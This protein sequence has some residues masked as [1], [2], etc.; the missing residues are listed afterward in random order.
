MCKRKVGTKEAK[1]KCERCNYQANWFS[2]F[3]AHLNRKTK[4]YLKTSEVKLCRKCDEIKPRSEFGSNS[5]KYLRPNCFPCER[6]VRREWYAKNRERINA[7]QKKKREANRIE[8]DEL[9]F[10][11][12]TCKTCKQNKNVREF[13]KQGQ[14]KNGLGSNCYECRSK[15]FQDVG[16]NSDKYIKGIITMN[17][18]YKLERVDITPELIEMTRTYLSLKREVIKKRK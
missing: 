14:Y 18:I 6:I 1:Y 5:P 10:T 11:E 17:K 2:D 12:K 9:D 3:K 4:C 15:K 16:K 8:Y 7:R 13:M